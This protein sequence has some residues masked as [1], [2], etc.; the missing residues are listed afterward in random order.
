MFCKDDSLTYLNKLGYN[1][2][3][4]PRENVQPLLVIAGKKPLT[5]L[6]PL[7]D[8][9]TGATYSPKVVRGQPAPTITGKKTN[10][11]DTS[12]GL[13][14]ANRLL[15][16]MGASAGKLDVGYQHASKIEVF[17]ENVLSDSV[18]PTEI[19][20]YLL[21]G[22]P[23]DQSL[24]MESIDKE[25]RA[26]VITETI[27]SN[28]FGVAAYDER[29]VPIKVNVAEIK[30]LLGAS[31]GVS[32][33]GTGDHHLSF[34]GQVFLA[35]GFRAIGFTVIKD[36]AGPRFDLTVSARPVAMKGGATEPQ[37]ESVVFRRN[38]LLELE[39]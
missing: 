10:K 29:S 6:G 21:S 20:K 36:Q 7:S 28:S 2:I 11:L 23:V 8:F 22:R 33:S 35:F 24:L 30:G 27:R 34:Q 16:A 19:D 32:I 38:E 13:E 18:F 1:V 37:S 31:A 5:V 14:L 15:S 9:T 26:F 3:L 17:F 25:G 12:L 4:Y 39:F